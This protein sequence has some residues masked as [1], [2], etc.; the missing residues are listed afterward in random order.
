MTGP[1][2]KEDYTYSDYFV[3][4]NEYQKWMSQQIMERDGFFKV[5][6][7]LLGA[8]VGKTDDWLTSINLVTDLPDNVNPLRVLPIKIP[9]KIF[10]DIGSYSEAWKENPAT[11]RFIYDAGIQLSFIRSILNIYIPVLFSKVYKDY[12]KSTITQNRF[13]RTI[14]FNIDLSQLQAKKLLNNIP[15]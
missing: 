1:N 13:L 4:R 14:S 2:G 5:N 12:Y 7:D 10:A 9:F 3:G 11:G 6:T 15:F 8:K